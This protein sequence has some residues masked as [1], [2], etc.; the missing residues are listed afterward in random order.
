M[1]YPEAAL[2]ELRGAGIK[3]GGYLPNLASPDVYARARCTVHV[4]RQQYAMAMSGIPTIRVFEALA[5]GIPLIS[6]PWLDTEHLFAPGDYQTVRSTDE[7][8]D[9]MEWLLNDSAAAAEQSQRGLA[10][11]QARHTCAHRAQEL[12]RICEEVLS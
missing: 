7:M 6:A 1:R 8:I 10:A 2:E 4:P 5:S 11:I 3:F 9:T 12:T